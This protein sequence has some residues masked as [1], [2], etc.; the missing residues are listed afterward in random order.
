MVN[1]CCGGRRRGG[2]GAGAGRS[3]PLLHYASAAARTVRH[4]VLL[5]TAACFCLHSSCHTQPVRGGPWEIGPVPRCVPETHCFGGGG[6]YEYVDHCQSRVRVVIAPILVPHGALHCFESPPQAQRL[7]IA[8]CKQ[9]LTNHN[10]SQG[11]RPPKTGG[12]SP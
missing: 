9:T 6:V 10:H 8:T 2:C 7:R 3:P 1:K 4:V 11:D 5:R 12:G